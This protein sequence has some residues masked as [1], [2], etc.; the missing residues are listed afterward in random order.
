MSNLTTIDD[1]LAQQP[2]ETRAVLQKVREEIHAAAP[3]VEEILSYQI[4]N[5]KYKGAL[6]SFGVAKDY[7][8]FYIMSNPAMETLKDDLKDYKVSG[9]SVHFTVD[10]PLPASLIKKI[11][12]TRV[13]ENDAK[14]K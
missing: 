6:V 1:Y 2:A 9:T 4:P 8:S 13:K 10:T 14:Q 11:V 7:I 5:F 12:T 3:D